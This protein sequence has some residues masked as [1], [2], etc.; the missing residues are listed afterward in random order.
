M[1]PIQVTDNISCP[2]VKYLN[3]S[4]LN[5][6]LYGLFMKPIVIQDNHSTSLVLAR[7]NKNQKWPQSPRLV[8]G[9]FVVC[10]Y[11][12]V[13]CIQPLCLDI[14]FLILVHSSELSLFLQSKWVMAVL[15]NASGGFYLNSSFVYLPGN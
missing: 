1:V 13:L 4:N 8:F 10:H 7:L 11:L 12:Q 5:F 9:L 6:V 2:R 15:S 3:Y 14:L